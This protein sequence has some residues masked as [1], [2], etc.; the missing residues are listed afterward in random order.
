MRKKRRNQSEKKTLSKVEDLISSEKSSMNS[1]TSDVKV[2]SLEKKFVDSICFLALSNGLK[3]EDS[4]FAE[5]KILLK[6]NSAN[7]ISGTSSQKCK[8]ISLNKIF[9]SFRQLVRDVIAHFSFCLVLLSQLP[10]THKEN[11][12]HKWHNEYR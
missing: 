3:N 9:R 8:I 1:L 7:N 5:T 11:P 12:D 6:N 4:K 10:A 2:N